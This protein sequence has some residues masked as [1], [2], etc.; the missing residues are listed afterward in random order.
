MILLPCVS[1]ARWAR[2]SVTGLLVIAASAWGATVTLAADAEAPS[3]DWQT[4]IQNYSHASL[5]VAELKVAQA[6]AI[7]RATPG[8]I[9]ADRVD[10][11]TQLA[12][13]SL[14]RYTA[15][16]NGQSV[17]AAITMA[18]VAEAALAR[19]EKIYS[20]LVKANSGGIAIPQEQ[21]DLA[22]ARVEMSKSRVAVAKALGKQPQDVRQTW[23]LEMLCDELTTLQQ[24]ALQFEASQ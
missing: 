13:A 7:N 12:E 9:S 16:K 23:E 5:Q 1:Y 22:K 8:T 4:L 20:S 18:A 14:A 24:I 2:K 11:L 19:N 6:K 15:L 3:A 21:L 10:E 17:D